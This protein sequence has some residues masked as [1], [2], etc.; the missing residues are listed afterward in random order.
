MHIS[1][2]HHPVVI[3]GCSIWY[4]REGALVSCEMDTVCLNWDDLSWAETSYLR[5]MSRTARL[6]L[7]EARDRL[8]G[9]RGRRRALTVSARSSVIGCEINCT[10]RCA[11]Y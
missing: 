2:V 3:G 6:C 8:P 5:R 7:C 4:M 9:S 1:Y 10:G 11:V